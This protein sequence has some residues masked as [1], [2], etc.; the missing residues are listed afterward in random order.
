M[1]SNA[2]RA[3]GMTLIEVVIAI[4]VIAMCVTAVVGL[5][6][7]IATRSASSMV[8][9]QST[10]IASAYMEEILSKAFTG[11]SNPPGRQNFDDVR[12]YNNLLDNGAR[13]HTGAPIAGLAQ[14]RVQVIVT[15]VQLGTAPDNVPA[16]RADVRVTG[17]NGSVVRLLGYRTNYAAQVL[18]DYT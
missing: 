4:T 12:D 13:D 15:T 1:V 9:S 7:A 6:S 10:A 14:Y 18:H 11:G 3:R 8:A 2:R 5:L 17:P 16:R